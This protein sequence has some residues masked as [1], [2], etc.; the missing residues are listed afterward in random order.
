[1]ARNPAGHEG[2]D[3]VRVEA[4]R[5]ADPAFGREAELLVRVQTGQE[6][7]AGLASGQ[8]EAHPLPGQPNP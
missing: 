6:Q 5:L 2:I 8:G 7:L 4:L 3:P 1:M